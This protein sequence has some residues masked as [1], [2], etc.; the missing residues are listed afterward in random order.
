MSTKAETIPPL[1]THHWSR[2]YRLACLHAAPL[3]FCADH[4]WRCYGDFASYTH[5]NSFSTS[6]SVSNIR[7]IMSLSLPLFLCLN[8]Q[9]VLPS[10]RLRTLLST[11]YYLLF[12]SAVP[13]SWAFLS[14]IYL[15]F[16]L[17]LKL[18]HLSP[19][20]CISDPRNL[21]LKWIFFP[22]QQAIW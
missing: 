3:Q 19:S 14:S 9:T 21:H 13:H 6:S 8:P 15:L 4:I 12:S 2:Q 16:D 20:F 7:G 5:S 1:T 18:L 10:L 22:I 17:S 11:P